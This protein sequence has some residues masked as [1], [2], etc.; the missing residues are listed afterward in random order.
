MKLRLS[1]T[2]RVP[3]ADE[4]EIVETWDLRELDLYNNPAENG[5]WE[6]S[7]SK[8]VLLAILEKLRTQHVEEFYE[9]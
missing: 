3:Y 8:E 1:N 6:S 4:E 7:D 2:W 5:F 9:V